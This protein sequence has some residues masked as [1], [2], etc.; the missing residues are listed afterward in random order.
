LRT[1]EIRMEEKAGVVVLETERLILRKFTTDDAAFMLALLNEPSFIDNI[2][3]K[4]VKTIDEAVS[5]IQTGPMASY[6]RLGFG[7]YLVELKE[8][9]A[10][11]GMCGLIKRDE[12]PDIDVGF[13]F[14]PAYWSKGYASEA[15]RAVI[16]FGKREFGIRRTVAIVRPDNSGSIRVLEKLGLRFDRL[17]DVF[18]DGSEL[19]LFVPDERLVVT[20][21]A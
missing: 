5:Y 3:D 6:Q 4:G 10:A 20:P 11:I 15:A 1:N 13:A 8:G 18:G 9:G 7:A 17:V 16:D 14:L 19:S 21:P 2:G 12:L